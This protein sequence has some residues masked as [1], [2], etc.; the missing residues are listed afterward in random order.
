LRLSLFQ[1]FAT[2]IVL[3]N[4]GLKSSFACGRAI[5]PHAV[6]D[7]VPA[8]APQLIAKNATALP[9]DPALGFEGACA[10]RI[11]HSGN[12]VLA[13]SCMGVNFC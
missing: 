6:G 4:H 2:S 1:Q 10:S 9:G 8:T 13:V 11:F 3:P 7:A 5:F 12:V